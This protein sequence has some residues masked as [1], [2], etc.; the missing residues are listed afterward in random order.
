[1]Y[2]YRGFVG[3]IEEKTGL[4]PLRGRPPLVFKIDPQD[5]YSW[6][7]SFQKA[8]DDFC[9]SYDRKPAKFYLRLE[10]DICNWSIFLICC[11]L[12]LEWDLSKIASVKSGIYVT[13][14]AVRNGYWIR[15]IKALFYFES[16]EVW[17]LKK[18]AYH[19]N[20]LLI[21]TF[22]LFFLDD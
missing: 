16:F 1:M 2:F 15:L 13:W 9:F 7:K 6:E 5:Y 14:S 17:H 8:V 19:L 22:Y 11:G 21:F 4:I 18:R 10:E 3:F 20:L 12:M